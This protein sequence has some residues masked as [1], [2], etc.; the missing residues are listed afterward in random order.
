MMSISTT[1]K[2][3][4]LR[5]KKLIQHVSSGQENTYPMYLVKRKIKV[6]NS[7]SC[8]GRIIGLKHTRAP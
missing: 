8:I 6:V 4:S 7:I 3:F 1:L 2:T 5:D